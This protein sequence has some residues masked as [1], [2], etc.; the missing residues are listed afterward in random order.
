MKWLN[1]YRLR[2]VLVGIVPVMIHTGVNVRA[3]YIWVQKAVMPAT[4][5]QH[6]SSVVAGK[7][8]VIGGWPEHA[9]TRVDEYDPTTDTWT[10]K[11]DMPTARG[12]T[13]A[14]VVNEKI[15][16]MD[17]DA[18]AEP[19]SIVEAYDPVTDTWAEQTELPTKRK[20][21]TTCVVDGI[22][23]VIGGYIPSISSRTGL[24]EAYDPTT[25]TWTRKTDMPTIKTYTSSCVVDG[26]IYVFGGAWT[27]EVVEVYDPA[28]DTWTT[29]LPMPTPRYLLDTVVV[30]GKIYAIGGYYHSINGPIYATV[31]VYDP[32]TDTW[33]KGVDIP[34]TMAGM[35]TSVVDGKIYVIGGTVATH[36]G[37]N[38]VFT[39]AVYA[40]EPI[41]DLNG[42]GIVDSADMCIVVDHWGTD[43]SLCDIG[44]MP[45]GDGVVD[46]QDLIILSE[47][48]FEDVNDPTLIAHWPLDEAQGVI[49]YNNAS[50]RDGTL[51]NGPVWQPDGGM[52]GGALQF[53]GI[54]DYVKTDP[55]LSVADGKF[56][57][58]AWIQ[59]GA[60]GQ[61]VI[62][63]EMG[64]NWLML[65]AEGKLATELK[66]TGRGAAGPLPSEASI[67]DGT[68]HRIAFVWDGSYRH[69][70]VDGVEVS[71]DIEPQS[72]LKGSGGGLYLGVGSHLTP[73][74]FFSGLIDD[75]RIYN[76]I[77]SP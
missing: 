56:S 41:V 24:V 69:L 76:R 51:V 73:G 10:R 65:E 46:V 15:Y 3:D 4:R 36:P 64:S 42:D 39:S 72:A 20:Q 52:V 38:W 44:P 61:V 67:T 9:L 53:D 28:T 59:A 1:D 14:S 63:A 45:W 22:I 18:E 50:D 68:W 12:F 47:H 57:V 6:S 2:L 48:L 26:K 13:S 55:I 71:G 8:Y 40:N 66:A 5:Y 43:N 23:Y 35:S 54:D 32:Q 11:A 17:G 16:V 58:V 30:D 49:A 25:D 62:S 21:F 27:R 70:Y 29:K 31:E 74:T 60:P 77:V 37:G 7:I 33:T 19:I 75:I 34:M